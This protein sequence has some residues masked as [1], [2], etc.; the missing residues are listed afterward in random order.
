VPF[1]E[2]QLLTEAPALSYQK[3][4]QQ[5]THYSFHTFELKSPSIINNKKMDIYLKQENSDN[6]SIPLIFTGKPSQPYYYPE[7][8]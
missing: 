6:A 5:I 8:K 3:Y 4:L 2:A 1:T 7:D